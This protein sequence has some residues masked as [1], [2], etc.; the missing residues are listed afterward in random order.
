MGSWLI[1]ASTAISSASSRIDI[2]DMSYAHTCNRIMR[3]RSLT[4]IPYGTLSANMHG[5]GKQYDL[6][7]HQR[8]ASRLD[9]L[10]SLKP[11]LIN[12]KDNGQVDW[13][14]EFRRWV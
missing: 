8:D 2:V 5:F 6:E 4:R 7:N 14:A 9:I 12:V 1:L 10:K 11:L 13:D 3:V